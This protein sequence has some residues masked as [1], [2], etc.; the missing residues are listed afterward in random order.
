MNQQPGL[1][2]LIAAGHAGGQ[3]IGQQSSAPPIN[4]LG[5]NPEELALLLSSA[6]G[7]QLLQPQ[8]VG[9]QL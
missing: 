4:F 8:Q 6:F 2:A 3:P 7:R 9:S 1:G 5:Q